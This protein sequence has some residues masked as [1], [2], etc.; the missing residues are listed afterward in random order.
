MLMPTGWQYEWME[1][2]LHILGNEEMIFADHEGHRGKIGYSSVGGCY[3]SCKMAVLEGLARERK[4]AGAIILREASSGYVP[5]GV[6]NVRENVR[7]AMLQTPVEFEDIKTA[8]N[9][10]SQKLTLPISRF[11]EQSMLLR[12]MLKGRQMTLDGF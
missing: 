5:L 8:L 6:F 1:A 2:F 12:K 10:C 9:Y 7:N 4:Q 11:I 3:Y